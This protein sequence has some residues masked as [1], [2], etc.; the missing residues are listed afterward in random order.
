MELR[1]LAAGGPVAEPGGEGVREPRA[2]VAPDLEEH[3]G[4]AGSEPP[5]R[6]LGE[7][8]THH[9]V[10]GAH[11]EHE[12]PRAAGPRVER[13]VGGGRDVRHL[14]DS[15]RLCLLGHRRRQ[16]AGVRADDGEGTVAC[17]E[18][19]GVARVEEVA[20]GAVLGEAEET[21]VH[22]APAVDVLDGEL[23]ALQ[24]LQAGHG[25]AAEC[26]EDRGDR[27]G[28]ARPDLPGGEDERAGALGRLR[29]V[30]VAA[31][32]AGARERAGG[33][34]RGPTVRAGASPAA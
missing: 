22:P 15:P 7:Q 10:R 24:R 18:R 12:R 5:D 13:E 11:P 14:Q 1:D 30:A 31:V 34:A 6:E 17:R 27:Q 21:A 2:V 8:G 32:R 4:A 20:A 25:V 23:R 33:R 26:R 28:S 29:P 9:L 19:R 3:R 16:L